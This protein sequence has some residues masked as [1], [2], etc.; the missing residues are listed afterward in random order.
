ML[1]TFLATVEVRVVVNV[2]D[3]F[4]DDD[5]N[6]CLDVTG[7]TITCGQHEIDD[8][9]VLDCDAEEHECDDENDK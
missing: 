7:T 9:S 3:A 2:P 5:F 8:I 6:A 4:D 1:K